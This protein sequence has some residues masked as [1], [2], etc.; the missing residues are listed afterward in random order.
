MVVASVELDILEDHIAEFHRLDDGE[1]SISALVRKIRTDAVERRHRN[2]LNAISSDDFD[3]RIGDCREMLADIADNSIPLIMTDPPYG[4]EAEP[5]YEWLAQF[6]A[7]VLIPGGSLI[8][9]TGQGTIFRD[10][11]IFLKHL[12]YNWLCEMRHHNSQKMFGAGVQCTFKPILWFVKDHRRADASGFRTLM[13]DSVRS[14]PDKNEH[15]WGQGTGGVH[16]WIHRLT[17][18]GE[19]IVDP[20]AGTAEW[21]LISCVA[22][23]KWTGCDLVEGGTTTIEAGDYDVEYEALDEAAE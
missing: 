15:A 11:N 2:S 7:R 12:K 23:R 9:Y 5:L 16:Q 10:G 13:P 17:E 19:M 21:G 8:C 3:L 14:T 4:N 1:S 6:A 20:F 18:P 22:G